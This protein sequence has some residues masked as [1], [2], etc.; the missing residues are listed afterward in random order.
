MLLPQL[1]ESLNILYTGKLSASS[2]SSGVP[3]HR[4]SFLTWKTCFYLEIRA[5]FYCKLNELKLNNVNA[6]S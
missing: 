2:L 1:S 4:M 5:S 6:I 3:Q